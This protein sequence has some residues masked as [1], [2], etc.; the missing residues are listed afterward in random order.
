[1]YSHFQIAAK[2][3]RYY[4]TSA[5]GKGH[6]IH[7][8]FV[9]DFIT[10]VLN[11]RR[12]FYAYE[13]LELLRSRLLMEQ[14]EIVVDDFGA[15]PASHEG[16][17]RT[18]SSIAKNAAKPRKLAQLLFRVVNHY[19]PKNIL[20]LGTSLGISTGYL[21]MGNC[22]STVY[23]CEGAPG[24][25]RT[26]RKNFTEL[27]LANIA[28]TEGNFDDTLPS[29]LAQIGTVDLAFVDGNHRKAPTLKYFEAIFEKAGENSILIFDDI[30]WSAEMEEAWTIIKQH[31]GVLLTIDLFFLGFVFLSKEF[32]AKQDFVIRF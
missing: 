32:K 30:H 11:D 25:A 14:A 3:I 4:L 9:Y 13:K 23:T 18:I 15:G 31:P 28:I 12:S 2:Y 24:I 20:E 7:S 17:S 26:A 1:M 27:E 22:R 10:L 6:G 19:Q 21:A 29:L 8:P 16:K 5:N